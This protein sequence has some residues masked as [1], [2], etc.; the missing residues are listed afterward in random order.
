MSDGGHFVRVNVESLAQAEAGGLRHNHDP[1]RQRGSIVEHGP[2]M[3]RRVCQNCVG[4]HDG[5]DLESTQDLEH[6][7]SVGTPV[8]AVLVLDDRDIGLIECRRA[9]DDRAW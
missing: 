9:G 7:V 5:G 8:E 1:V 6:L 3:R 2:L 4:D